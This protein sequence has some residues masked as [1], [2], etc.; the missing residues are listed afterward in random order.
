MAVTS[1]FFNS[2]SGDRKYNARQWS[3]IFDGLIS[4]GVYESVG[5]AFA[6][7]PNSGM[8]L[9]VAAG[10]AW[11]DHSWILNDAV[12]TITIPESETVLD[13][14]DAVVIEVNEN[15][16]TRAG[17]IKVVS[18]T[19]SS[20]AERPTLTDDDEVHQHPICYVTVGK[21][22]TE[23]T[24]SD[25]T[26][27]V[28]TSEC[29]YVC[30]LI[31]QV[32][33]D[34]LIAQ[35]QAQWNEWFEKKTT[36]SEDAWSTWYQNMQTTITDW[37]SSQSSEFSTWFAGIKNTL[38]GDTAGHLLNLIHDVEDGANPITQTKTTVYDGD[39][40]TVTFTDG[41]KL[42]TTYSGDT[43]TDKMYSA[44]NAL[45]WTKT[46]TYNGDTVTETIEEAS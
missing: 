1:G 23:I 44:E 31:E 42:I 41:R 29:P 5:S 25:I 39:T 4:D 37:F 45:Q 21:G 16:N 27:V 26:Y 43:V 7:S 19:A 24:A 10:R 34:N 17:T 6:V 12:T 8:V 33:I 11:F 22:V 15:E 30:G 18:G 36:D 32:T 38:D 28:G 35:W 13:R 14:I 9:N 46:T 20:S 3:S 2:L 40:V